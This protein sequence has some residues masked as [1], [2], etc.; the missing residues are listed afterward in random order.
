MMRRRFGLMSHYLIQRVPKLE[1]LLLPELLAL[2]VLRAGRGFVQAALHG[3]ALVAE[4]HGAVGL[5]VFL[6]KWNVCDTKVELHRI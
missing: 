2:L 5:G 4:A 1:P 3:L 6:E